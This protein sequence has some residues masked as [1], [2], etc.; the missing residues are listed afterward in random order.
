[1]IYKNAEIHN[2]AEIEINEKDGGITWYRMP[3]NLTDKFEISNAKK[4]NVRSTGVEIRF[5]IKSGNAVV[6]LRSV[7]EDGAKGSFHVF[8]GGIQGGYTE[9]NFCVDTEPRDY[10]IEKARN[11]EILKKF[12]EEAGDGFNPEVIRLVFESGQYEILDISGDIEP[13]PKEWTPRKTLFCYGSSITHGALS[14]CASHS[15][16]SVLAHNLHMDLRNLGMAGSCAA[17]PCV[18]DYIASEGENGKWDILILELGANVLSWDDKKIRER[19]EY[20]VTRT[21][22]G[23]PDK[24]IYV[25]SP[26]LGSSDLHGSTSCARWRKIV[27]ET[28]SRLDFKNVIYIEGTELLN[29]MSLL[30]ADEVHPNIYGVRKIADRLTDIIKGQQE[31]I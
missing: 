22:K 23:N 9:I 28:V 11:P 14:L 13:P 2:A 27:G 8:R 3:K 1:M 19:T 24:K 6:R 25:I 31:M 17:E 21:A 29:N 4:M 18:I 5:V 10:I 30:T 16:A 7:S 26:L 20:A 12:S 15:W